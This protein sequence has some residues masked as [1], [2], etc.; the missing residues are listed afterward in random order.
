MGIICPGDSGPHP[1]GGPDTGV[2]PDSGPDGGPSCSA[3]GR[4]GSTCRMGACMSGSTC[5]PD[6]MGMPFTSVFTGIKMG[7]GMDPMHAGYQT[8]DMPQD[9]AR[10]APMNAFP[11]GFCGQEC[12]TS[13]TTNA[14]GMCAHC[15]SQ[16]TQLPIIQAFGGARVFFGA[17][18][19]YPNNEGLCRLNCTWSP[20]ARSPECPGDAFACSEFE[21]SCIEACTTDNECNTLYGVTYEGDL[22]STLITDHP[23]HCNHTTGRC[24]YTGHAGAM[25]GDHCAS[26]DDCAPGTGICLNGGLCAEFGCTGGMTC[27]T[28]GICLGVSAT[29]DQTLCLRGCNTAADCGAGNTCNALTGGM[30]IGTW[31]GYCIGVCQDDSECSAD[32]VCTNYTD[33]TGANQ[34]G[35]CVPRCD[36]IGAI[37]AAAGTGSAH[38]CMATE[39]CQP[40][41]TS[42]TPPMAT[43]TYGRCAPINGFCGDAN[44]NPAP[45]AAPTECPTGYV[46]DETLAGLYGDGTAANPAQRDTFGDGHCVTA[47]ATNADCT[48][49]GT[50]CVTTGALQG[51]CR[52]PCSAASTTCPTHQTCSTTLGYCIE[53]APPA[54]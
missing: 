10:D 24:E 4:V 15:D 7:N 42:G 38:T 28:N 40:A 29:N 12:D 53:V 36:H 19:M 45:A 23:Q 1:D 20:T 46:C 31:H 26:G 6:Q 27:G 22:V 33:T 18:A 2:R 41:H 52:Q 16:V 14:C 8:V 44:S 5:M 43:T 9:P 47:C 3:S 30:S 17:R 54:M 13:A 39:W 51:L 50:E 48:V 34:A 21:G 11:G 32:E 25:V 49:S 35:R 37:G